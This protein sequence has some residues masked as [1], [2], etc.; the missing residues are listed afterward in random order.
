VLGF[1]GPVFW[2]YAYDDFVDYTFLGYGYDTFWPTAFDDF[3]EGIYGAYAPEFYAG[4]AEAGGYAD[5]T[6]RA[7]RRRSYALRSHA[8]TAAA[9]A[10]AAQAGGAQVCSG[11]AQGL[12]DF[13]IQRIAEQV[14]PNKDERA[15]LDQLKSATQQALEVLRSAC[16]T[17]LPTTP[18][19][20][21]AAVRARVEA[22][23]RAVQIV[24]PAL[25]K[26]YASLADEQKERFNELDAANLSA[27]AAARQRPDVA[28]VCSARA[29][30]A[31]DA[32]ITRI[33][34]TLHLSGAQD[35]ALRDVKGASVKAADILAQNCP[36]DQPLTPTGR[37][38]AMEQRLNSMLQAI[39]TVQPALVAF[40]N[41]LNDEQKAQLNRVTSRPA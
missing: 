4:T 35:A 13:P 17:D 32:S 40:Y 23:L 15:R 29:V 39:D 21:M 8:R 2:P 3:Y 7:S 6:T 14:Q 41:S 38:A 1:I 33:A 30:P 28:R 27:A 9:S 22:M 37:L 34:H 26:F 36:A 24:R 20:R 11:D 10:S 18:T 12:T 5:E 31:L 19:A 25:E 16:P